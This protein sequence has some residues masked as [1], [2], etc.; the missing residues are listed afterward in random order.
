MARAAGQILLRPP[1]HDIAQGDGEES[2]TLAKVVRER[3][4][5]ATAGQWLAL[6]RE[7]VADVK[8]QDVAA[9]IAMASKTAADPGQISDATLQAAATKSRH[10][11]DKGASQILLGGPPVPAGPETDAKVKDLFKQSLTSSS[12]SN[13]TPSRNQSTT[14]LNS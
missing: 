12:G 4:R 9:R 11:S 1:A 2:P 10:G 7:C 8:H 14:I 3:L 13:F 5:K 6:V